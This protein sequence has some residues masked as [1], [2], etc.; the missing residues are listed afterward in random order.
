MGEKQYGYIRSVID[1]GS[2]RTFVWE[3]AS[4]TLNQKVMGHCNF[5]VNTFGQESTKVQ[6]CRIVELR[7]HNSSEGTEVITN[8]V[9]IPFIHKDIMRLPGEHA[10]VQET[11]WK[12]IE[13]WASWCEFI[14][15]AYFSAHK[16]DTDTGKNIPKR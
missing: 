16:K 1:G 8:A 13:N 15:N 14:M 9:E 4:K 12:R 6:K 11:E 5:H 7:L 2:Q 10:L 3:G